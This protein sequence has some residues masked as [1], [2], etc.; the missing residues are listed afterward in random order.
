M[1]AST[2]RASLLS[3]LRFLRP[4][5]PRKS[6]KAALPCALLSVAEGAE[7]RALL[8]LRGTDLELEAC[9]SVSAAD[10]EP[11]SATVEL[12]A[13]LDTLRGSKAERVSL[14][15]DVEAWRLSVSLS[16]G[17]CLSLSLGVD[18][19]EYPCAQEQPSD[20]AAAVLDPLTLRD[21]LSLSAFA[22]AREPGRYAMHGVR[23]KV[24]GDGLRCV[25]TDGRR[26][27]VASAPT[28]EGR[29]ADDFSSEGEPIAPHPWAKA[30]LGTHAL[31]KRR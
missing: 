2:D 31:P 18:V 22:A 24:E 16:D 14:S 4:A 25:A 8:S 11:G 3:A 12:S 28:V 13:L 21:A 26:L 30:L 23:F 10:V 29:P 19:E 5:V 27:S 15:V 7:G 20:G 1:K 17:A 9:A 6:P